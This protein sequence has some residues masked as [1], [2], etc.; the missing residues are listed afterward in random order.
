M[1]DLDLCFNVES[2]YIENA[3]NL[4]YIYRFNILTSAYARSNN[5]INRKRER[6]KINKIKASA[7][8]STTFMCSVQVLI[9]A[10]RRRRES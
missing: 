8:M 9:P 3:M 10:V 1:R 2:T 6:E 5:L 4:Y 7:S